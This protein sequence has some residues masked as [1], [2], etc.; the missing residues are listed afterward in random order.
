MSSENKD[1]FSQSPEAYLQSHDVVAYLNH[2]L[3]SLYHV[4]DSDP[5]LQPFRFLSDYFSSVSA[6]R[7]LHLLSWT[8]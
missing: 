7:T 2:A 6:G 8:A 5:K 3:T 1:R 4:K